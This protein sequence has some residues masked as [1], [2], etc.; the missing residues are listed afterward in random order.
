M[1]A[2]DR[3]VDN[4]IFIPHKPVSDE[5]YQHICAGR[6]NSRFAAPKTKTFLLWRQNL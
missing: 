1:R 3:A 4:G 5:I 6:L 2:V